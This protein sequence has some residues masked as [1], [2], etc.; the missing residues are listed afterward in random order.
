MEFQFRTFVL[1]CIIFS[2]ENFAYAENAGKL[3]GHIN[4]GLTVGF[5]TDQA[6]IDLTTTK[7]AIMRNIH[8]KPPSNLV[9]LV[10]LANDIAKSLNCTLRAI[11]YFSAQDHKDLSLDSPTVLFSIYLTDN[12][13]FNK[14]WMYYWDQN[15]NCISTCQKDLPSVL[16]TEALHLNFL[17]CDVIHSKYE[18]PFSLGIFT[19]SFDLYC[20]IS[21]CCSF[22]M[23]VVYISLETGKTFASIFL[24][25]LSTLLS[26]GI[27][28]S[29]RETKKLAVLVIWMISCVFLTNMYLGDF[30]SIIVQPAEPNVLETIQQLYKHNFTLLFLLS[31][32]TKR[33]NQNRKSFYNV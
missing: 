10:V 23:V 3:S 25:L 5:D 1:L 12:H 15:L 21:L 30:T 17:Y 8:S 19:Q 29:T 4:F 24:I 20:W 18:S 26:P 7:Y 6:F 22:W 11:Q 32:Y 27:S 2:L 28:E 16:V 14:T 13:V 33:S 31:K 9:P